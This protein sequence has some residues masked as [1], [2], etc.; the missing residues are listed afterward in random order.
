MLRN[1][2]RKSIELMNMMINTNIE[3]G[4]KKR[5]IKLRKKSTRTNTEQIDVTLLRE[6]K[7]TLQNTI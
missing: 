7:T 3:L 1:Q 4:T 6:S 2:V 5:K